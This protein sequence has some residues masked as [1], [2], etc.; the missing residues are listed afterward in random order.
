M[1]HWA[2]GEE[3]VAWTFQRSGSSMSRNVFPS[4]AWWVG[5]HGQGLCARLCKDNVS[6]LGLYRGARLGLLGFMC[7]LT[8][9]RSFSSGKN[10]AEQLRPHSLCHKCQQQGSKGL[11]EVILLH[12]MGQHHQGPIQAGDGLDLVFTLQIKVGKLHCHL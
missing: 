10:K 11:G 9:S 4:L 1:H 6:N 2:C 8:H 5:A 7:P 12:H 3:R